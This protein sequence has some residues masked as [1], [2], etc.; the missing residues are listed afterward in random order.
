[1]PRGGNMQRETGTCIEI[2]DITSLHTIKIGHLYLVTPF[3][4]R[5]IYSEIPY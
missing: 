3:E 1:M 5:V 2:S 4:Q